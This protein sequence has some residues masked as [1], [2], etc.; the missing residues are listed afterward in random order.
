MQTRGEVHIKQLR[1]NQIN[2]LFLWKYFS[3]RGVARL[4]DAFQNSKWCN[5]FSFPLHI[6][7]WHYSHQWLSKASQK[8][9]C[10]VGVTSAPEQCI[11]IRTSGCAP[12]QARRD[13]QLTA[14]RSE[15][16]R[17]LSLMFRGGFLRGTPVMSVGRCGPWQTCPSCTLTER[18]HMAT[19]A[20]RT[21]P[22][23][24]GLRIVRQ[25][26]HVH[27]DHYT[28]GLGSDLPS[29]RMF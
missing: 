7:Y 8:S 18:S 26:C 22:V 15:D 3:D 19:E 5:S 17:P 28:A 1:M 4:S 13:G 21:R 20:E 14:A 11:C 23:N 2:S 25:Q 29:S 24:K 27:P 16:L 6:H 10:F 9:R 12:T